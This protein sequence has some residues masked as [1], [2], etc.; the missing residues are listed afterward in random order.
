MIHDPNP[1]PSSN[2]SSTPIKAAAAVPLPATTSPFVGKPGPSSPDARPS[3]KRG[4]DATVTLTT[5]VTGLAI[6]PDAGIVDESDEPATVEGTIRRASITK[7]RTGKPMDG[8]VNGTDA[9]KKKRRAGKN[10]RKEVLTEDAPVQKAAVES[11]LSPE[12]ARTPGSSRKRSQVRGNGWRDTPI[13]QEEPTNALRTPGVIGGQVGLQAVSSS[14]RKNRRQRATEAQSGWATEDA[15]DI[16]QLPDFDFES[17]LS[18]FDKRTVFDQIRNEDTTADEDRLVSFNRLPSRPGTFGGQKLHP[19]EAVL[20]SKPHYRTSE[21]SSDEFDF[22]SGRNSRRAMSRASTMRAPVRSNSGVQEDS[23][24][25]NPSTAGFLNRSRRS[26]N[27]PAYASSHPTGSPR[28]VHFSPPASPSASQPSQQLQPGFRLVS[29][30]HTCPTVTPGGMAAIE[31]VAEAEFGLSSDIQTENAARGIAEIAMSALNPGGRRLARDNINAKPVVVVLAGNHRAGSRAIAA[32]RHLQTRGLRVMACILGYE[33]GLADGDKD[34]RRQVEL[35]RKLGGLVRGWSD[36]ERYLKK[37][38]APPEL[39]VDALLAPSRDFE[40]LGVEDQD[41]CL[42]MVG[43]A[44]KSRA[45]V[46]S[47]DAPS[48]VNGSTGECCNAVQPTWSSSGSASGPD[49]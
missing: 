46:L 43:W 48:G 13:L 25:L 26:L 16:G 3:G 15:T 21:S 9:Q 36:V 23:I 19:T 29:S 8:P 37:L 47:V 35:L 45:Q 12:V 49:L 17:N 6:A 41:V 42:N 33:R 31:E 1:I 39:I 44:N 24:P 20:D 4:S 30:N 22:D 5:G 7:T 32:A 2:A 14:K 18:K 28:P 38:D 40:A 34:L 27:N 10:K 11:E